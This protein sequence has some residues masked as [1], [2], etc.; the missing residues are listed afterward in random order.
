VH[1]IE[2][3]RR[4][5]G[6]TQAG[7][8]ERLGVST[9]AVQGWESG[10]TPRPS[11]IP[12]LAGAL[13][14]TATDLVDALEL[15]R[16]SEVGELAPRELRVLELRYGLAGG[17]PH[18]LAEIGREFGI[19]RERARQI[20]AKA[21]DKVN[22]MLETQAAGRPLSAEAQQQIELLSGATPAQP[23]TER[24]PLPTPIGLDGALPSG[25]ARLAVDHN[26][27]VATKEKGNGAREH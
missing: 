15:W 27:R 14:V 3:Y 12:V 8:A 13:G 11:R 18:S 21:A 10:A 23:I 2:R 4:A 9:N 22:R 26:G 1:P 17:R 20:E 19:S 6:W 7:L 16:P 5:K 24:R 25:L